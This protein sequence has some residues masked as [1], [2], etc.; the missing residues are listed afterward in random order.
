MIERFLEL[1]IAA[2]ARVPHHYF[3]LPVA[4][5][6]DPIYRERVYS[7]ELYHQLRSVLET[8]EELA[9]YVLSGEIDKQGHPIIRPSAPDLVFHVP[10]S[11]DSNL[12]VVE[13]KP[14]NAELNGVQKDLANLTYFV[15][16]EVGY[17]CGVQLVYGDEDGAFVR[18]ENLYR[19]ANHPQ[20][21]LF[22]HQRPSEPPRRI[23]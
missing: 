17:Q 20:L 13:V 16:A 6:E 15:S 12:V 23:I 4:G 3:Q 14:V 11:M 5:R 21:L 9:R 10:K 18:F 8:D 22:W 7:Y 19:A 1:L 2:T